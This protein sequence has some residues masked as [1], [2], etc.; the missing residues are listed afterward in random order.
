MKRI[1]LAALLLITAIIALEPFG[2]VM[3][4][5]AQMTAAGAVVWPAH[6]D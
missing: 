4:T 3:P 5:S 6:P 1:V 2:I